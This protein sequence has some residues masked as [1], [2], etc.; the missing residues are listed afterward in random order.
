M[1]PLTRAL[2]SEIFM[3]CDVAAPGQLEAVYRRI[4]QD[5]GRLDFVQRSIA[6]ARKED[7]SRRITDCS[8]EGFAIAMNVSVQSF[9][10][11]AKLSEPL[12]TAGGR[13]PAMSYCGAPERRLVTLD[14]AGALRRIPC[15][16]RRPRP[17]L[18]TLPTS[19]PAITS[20]RGGGGNSFTVTAG[21]F[22]RS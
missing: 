13:S 4:A 16:R 5:W 11:M 20:G 8:A 14:D 12:M 21:F 6:Y 17:L 10:R 15:Q 7:L 18:E 1:R 9:L 22:T 2:Q 19:M 3:P